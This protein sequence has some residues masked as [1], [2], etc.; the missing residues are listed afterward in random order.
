MQY[1]VD[2]GVLD[3]AME[4]THVHHLPGVERSARSASA[5][6]E[7]HGKGMALQLNTLLDAGAVRVGKDGT[8]AV[9]A[10]KI[11]AARWSR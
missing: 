8:F 2:K 11:K 6:T 7:A 1:L 5:S 9:D 4:R 3:K 10:A